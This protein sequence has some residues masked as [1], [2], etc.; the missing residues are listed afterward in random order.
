MSEQVRAEGPVSD[1]EDVPQAGTVR[2][3]AEGRVEH[4][5]GT[6]WRPYG[7]LPDDGDLSEPRF[8][9]DDTAGPARP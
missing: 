9:L 7:E 6:A 8:R 5:D 2:I 3:N 1:G 4:Y